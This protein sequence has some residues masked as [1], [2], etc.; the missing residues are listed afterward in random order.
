MS[1]IDHEL[2]FCGDAAGWMNAELRA[3]PE[4]AFEQVKI[5]QSVRGS[6]CRRDLTV[7]DRVGKIAITGEVKLPYMPDGGSPYNDD[8]VADAHSKAA[9]VGSPYFLTWNV[10]RIVLW[11]TDDAGKPLFERHL[12][13]E[14]FVQVRDAQDLIAPPVREAIRKGL[15]RF[16]D[17]ASQAYLDVLPLARRPLDE[18]FITILEAALER[19][20]AVSQRAIETRYA[21][22]GRF[23]IQLDSW[24]R[25]T[26]Q[27]HLSDDELVKRDNLERA[28]KFT[29]FVL[30]N[31]I[32]F[33]QALRRRFTS[34]SMLRV[35]ARLSTAAEL[36]T[37]LAK[38]FTQAKRITRD[39][40]TVFDGD[41][42]DSLPFLSDHVVPAWRDLLKSIDRFDFTQV[43]YD[44]IGPIFE[45]LI[46]P[47]ERHRYGQHYTK[48]EIVDLINAFCIRRPDAVVLD[49]ACGGGT[50][51]VRAYNRKRFL[52]E[53]DGTDLPHEL[54]LDQLY[55]V[56]ISA[57]A[58]H[59]TTM[60]LATRDL[61]DEHNYPLIAQS[62]F[63]DIER[64]K[65]VFHIPALA[66]NGGAKL[67]R[68]VKIDAVDAVVGN[69]PYVR[70]EE[71]SKPPTASAKSRVRVAARTL[72]QITSE[73]TAYKNRLQASAKRVCPGINFSGRSDLHV[74]F[75][76]HAKTF[77]KN[78][79]WFGFLTSSSWLDVEYGFRLQ[80][81][82]LRTYRIVAVFESQVEPWFTGAR[83]TTCATI[84]Q[85]EPDPEKRDANLIRFV[86]LRSPLAEIFPSAA[87]EDQR[88]RATEA[89]RDRIESIRENVTERHWRVRVVRQ[90][91]LYRQGCA[92]SK[93]TTEEEDADLQAR[94]TARRPEHGSEYRGGKWGVH[95]RA[96]DLFF[97]IQ[98]R[99]A[100]RLVPLSELAKVRCGIKTG[101]DKFFF[102]RDVTETRLKE[103]PD[104]REFRKTY[105]L[106]PI[107]TDRIRI[108]LSGDGSLHLIEA[109]YLEPQ[110]HNL[111]ENNGVFGIQIDPND[112]RL[113]IL[114][115]GKPKSQLKRTHVLKYIEWGEREHF[116]ERPSC[117]RDP[118][119]YVKPPARRGD[120]LWPE[121]QQYRHLAP[122]NRGQL[123]CNHKVFDLLV[124]RGV[125]SEVLCGIMNSTLSAL[126]K[127][128]FGRLAGTEGNLQTAV[129]DVEL[130]LVPDAHAAKGGLRRRITAAL[131][132]MCR[133]PTMNLPDEFDLADRQELDDA[134]LELLGEP[135]VQERRYLRDKLYREITLMYRAIRD[136]ELQMVEFRKQTARGS[137]L[138]VEQIAQQVWD[139]LDPSLIRRFPEDFIDPDE[140]VEVIELPD[141]K[142]RIVDNSLLGHVG[143]DIDGH[144]IEIGDPA[145][146]D[147]L[148]GIFEC[149]RRGPVPIPK[150]PRVCETV[151]QR[152]RDYRAQIESEFAYQASQKTASEKFQ[153]KV[154]ANLR[155]RL[156]QAASPERTTHQ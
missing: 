56:D 117:N 20:I 49:P 108:V 152:F 109:E 76:P 94:G 13:E 99:Y 123:L 128:F 98:D 153:A 70:Q 64:G 45:R 19:P 62:D 81:F 127:H 89:L 139:E 91:D 133:R 33:Y 113:K 114:V 28:A 83:V 96:P 107:Q 2:T 100:S 144:Y 149:G 55:G 126:M 82:I 58:T 29:C 74:Y 90:G 106:Q 84:L 24:M 92:P 77:L 121:G 9:K 15:A 79:G 103:M 37:T 148:K 80:E 150:D 115:C 119:Y 48:P 146:A 61:I 135:D 75:W 36:E 46:S 38:F 67:F 17:R 59:L 155:H 141:G 4:L 14:V 95:L 7:T 105:G 27:W 147:L 104:A 93:D 53:G 85:R 65:E 145:R 18:F 143:V 101:C 23:K 140:P 88:Q 102:V 120:I 73:A 11:R 26:Q 52:A 125:R 30:V 142:L 137:T 118:W 129:V 21:R 130:M 43:N 138:S 63:F 134:V 3:R 34:L 72:G 31:K 111:M 154:V 1:T 151:D 78:D 50:F 116:H 86:Q 5:E 51:L 156:V 69:P 35:P 41:F 22:D 42:G 25:D 60:N 112:L 12:Y 122:F 39:Y 6:R 71:I 131:E 40:E 10:N 136:K 87:V 68:P 8:V 32:V 16:L 132:R 66:A 57:Y 47:E 110:V 44:V 124:H 97:K 54:L